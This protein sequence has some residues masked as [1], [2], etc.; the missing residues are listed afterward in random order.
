MA[1]QKPGYL[2]KLKANGFVGPVGYKSQS[3]LRSVHF[4]YVFVSSQGDS[5]KP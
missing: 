3:S 1:L 2:K 4:I 5:Q